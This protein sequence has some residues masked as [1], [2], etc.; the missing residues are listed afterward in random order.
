MNYIR[1]ANHASADYKHTAKRVRDKLEAKLVRDGV[2]E[3]PRTMPGNG[4]MRLAPKER[5][6]HC[7]S[8]PRA[9][10]LGNASGN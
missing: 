6:K 5:H 10:G 4:D 3:T 8:R 1:N 7:H 9:Y 2:G